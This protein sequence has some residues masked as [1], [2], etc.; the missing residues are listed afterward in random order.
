MHC[1]RWLLSFIFALNLSACN[2]LPLQ[3]HIITEDQTDDEKIQQPAEIVSSEDIKE[4]EVL[5]AVSEQH[6]VAV[7]TGI[8][9]PQ[10]E[11]IW[12]RINHGFSFDRHIQH[13]S[14]QAKLAWYKRNQD[15]IDRVVDRARPYIYHIVEELEKRQ[16]PSE[17]ALLPVVESA[18]HPFA[19]SPSRASGIWQFIPGTGKQYGLKQNWWYDGRRDI[20]AA[21][22]A[23]LD[24]LEKLHKEFNGDWLLALAAYNTGERNVARAIK[25]NKRRG[26]GTD[27]WSLRLPRETRGYV[28]SL[29]AV[30]ELVANSA[31]HKIT[32]KPV[33]NDVYFVQIDAGEQLD[34]AM[35]AELAGLSIDDFYTLNPAFNRW[36]T[37]PN[38][39]H[40][41]LIPVEKKEVFQ[42]KLAALPK[43]ERISWKRHI[44]KHGDSL[45]R[46]AARYRTS[47]STLKQV[48]G[49][50][51][52]LI[53]TDHSLLIPTSKRPLQYY[54]LSLDARRFRGLKKAGNG[55]Q[56]IYRV[57]RGDTLWDIG[58]QYGI[59]VKNLCAWNGISPRSI[60][61]P[62][63]KLNIW[64]AEDGKALAGQAITASSNLRV[65]VKLNTDSP[66]VY[67][68]R[69]G[70]SLWLISR[71]FGTTVA[72]LKKWNNM[73]K[74]KNVI[75][76]GQKLILHRKTTGLTDV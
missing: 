32:W 26:K 50:R 18:Y 40:T 22:R 10:F 29:L 72:Q 45:S 74:S 57:R 14:V 27:F 19:Y 67:T 75:K 46:I 71:R 62:G 37:D 54:T 59:S 1:K 63:Q 3:Q 23:A 15:Y 2:T 58:K 44:I 5:T 56:Y 34:L 8:S 41:L 42:E 17:L 33:P 38:G 70:D 11:N 9:D 7:D 30:T 31:T 65:P 21:T 20:T 25:R 6:P 4:Q 12:D 52:N 61:R 51:S 35:A 60:L 47:V 64:I 43:H 55:H 66:T 73:P 76:P 49:L 36:A 16:M 48:N 28:P 69:K 53:H 24:Y 68:V 39:P 13:R